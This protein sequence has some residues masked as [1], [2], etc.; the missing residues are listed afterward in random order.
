[1]TRRE[2]WMA[3]GMFLVAYALAS[4][5]DL[6][7]TVAAVQVPGIK[8]GNVAA[9]SNGAFDLSKALFA[10][11]VGGAFLALCFGWA[12]RR[13]E[14]VDARWLAHPIRSFA[15]V[16]L[17]PWREKHLGYSP[18]HMVSFCLAFCVT[19]VL[20]AI[21]NYQ[22]SQGDVGFLAAGI[23]RTA[24]VTNEKA[25]VVVVVLGL[26]AALTLV[27]APMAARILQLEGT[28]KTSAP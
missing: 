23:R 28:R 5:A 17:A 12:L 19:R 20:A 16:Y 25:A 26:Y 9:T 15:N 10:T 11:V 6:A 18:I 8:E 21:N 13:A 4:T 3:C 7:T 2:V 24:S 27:M 22:L 1:M 14:H